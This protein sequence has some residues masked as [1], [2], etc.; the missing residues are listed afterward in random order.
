MDPYRPEVHAFG[1]RAILGLA[2]GSAAGLAFSWLYLPALPGGLLT[3]LL[4]CGGFALGRTRELSSEISQRTADVVRHQQALMRS[5]GEHERR[6]AELL[7]E[8]LLVE[9]KV[10]ERTA[11]LHETG[12]RLQH[13]L[14][15]VQAL[16]YA[17][18]DFFNN[19]S[20]ELR[21][22]LT[23]ILAP[24]EDLVAGRTPPGGERVAFEAM[25]RSAT[26]LLRLINQLLDL[27]K[28]DAGEMKITLAATDLAQLLQ[29]TLSAFEVAA[30]KKGV[31]LERRLPATMAPIAVDSA[32]IESAVTNLIANALRLT[33]RGGAVRVRLQDD[34]SQVHITIS[35]DGPGIAPADQ[36]KVFERFAQGETAKPGLVGTG[37]GLAL[38]REAARLH[39]GTI[40]LDSELGKG[41]TFT[42]TLPR[43]QHET[44]AVETTSDEVA[45]AK[46][47][48]AAL[49][50]PALVDEL[51]AEV[52]A[53]RRSGPD[54]NAALVLVVE[55][56]A[57]LRDF[58]ADVLAVRYRV[59]TA[60]DG[61]QAL[62]MA[63]KLRPDAVV[64]DVAMPEMDGYALCQQIRARDEIRSTPVLLLTARTE[65]ASI[66]R[67][68]EAGAN[69]YILKPFHGRELLARVDVHIR[70]RRM[71]QE[72]ALRERHALLGV[73]AASVAHQVRNPLTTLCAG[74]PAMEQR[75][76]SK[77]DAQT[78]ELM[79]V[80][81]D[82][83]RRIEEM[84]ADLMN[85]ARVDRPAACRFR[86]ADGLK[87]ALRLARARIG[88]TG[89]L[90][91]RIEESDET[92]GW[93]GDMNHVFLNLLDN[94][95]R[96]VSRGGRIRVSARNEH[97]LYVIR[98]EDSGAGVDA[99]LASR[100]F[101][102]FFTTRPA[103]EGTGLGLA[104]AKDIVDRH[105]GRLSVS[106][107]E[108][109]GAMFTVSLPY[110]RVSLSSRPA[111]L[112]PTL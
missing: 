61:V 63:A 26:R 40:E 106:R 27:A 88:E 60:V 64:S 5:T 36:D 103:G 52:R 67:G 39:G 37:I 89:T 2:C 62:Y 46:N 33:S 51:R 17:R 65:A 55:D 110:L 35:D 87:T 28:I 19:V 32:W 112:A 34:G 104:I 78:R 53:G 6:Y 49:I 105:G 99:A 109:G 71:V 58:I 111:L 41:A 74:L 47:P 12:Q 15:Q 102:P 95:M 24:L 92:D 79:A 70:L 80:M 84:T 81:L 108:L 50:A 13:T 75:L 29:A 100:I 93:P 25:Q 16:S 76:G 30:A 7:D 31:L 82:C 38:V 68:F 43:R 44:A 1:F 107:S 11:D 20:H 86:P 91:E 97:E 18:T 10:A 77:V 57:D 23:L 9:N 83:A 101:E 96:A 42:L 4:A 48:T 3:A 72:L 8:K 59:Q 85:L 54:P 66:L 94:A 14:E 98:V 90:E 69:D 45:A 21:S 22:P 56:N 73:L